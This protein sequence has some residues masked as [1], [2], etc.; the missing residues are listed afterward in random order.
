MCTKTHKILRPARAMETMVKISDFSLSFLR[1]GEGDGG[2]TS[3]YHSTVF[4]SF[5]ILS[6]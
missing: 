1:E 4:S 6:S 2:G 5:S 3:E